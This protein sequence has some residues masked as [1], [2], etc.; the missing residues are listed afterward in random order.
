MLYN[1]Y[2]LNY[3]APDIAAHIDIHMPY[4]EQRLFFFFFSIFSLDEKRKAIKDVK[5]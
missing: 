4:I 3:H 5:R 1:F 2:Q